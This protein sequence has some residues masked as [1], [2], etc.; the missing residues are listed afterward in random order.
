MYIGQFKFEGPG[1]MPKDLKDSP[2]VYVLLK[3]LNDNCE[4]L[5]VGQ[6]ESLRKAWEDIDLRDITNSAPGSASLVAYYCPHLDR[7]QRTAIVNAILER[8]CAEDVRATAHTSGCRYCARQFGLL[9]GCK[10]IGQPKNRVRKPIR[11]ILRLSDNLIKGLLNNKDFQQFEVV[12]DMTALKELAFCLLQVC[13]Q[14]LGDKPC[15]A[16]SAHG[17][18]STRSSGWLRVNMN[19]LT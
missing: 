19:K 3:C 16:H 2:G 11:T 7:Q 8:V 5:D 15:V 4:L 9:L 14:E 13:L 18:R 1:L 12:R 17:R 6:S 10:I